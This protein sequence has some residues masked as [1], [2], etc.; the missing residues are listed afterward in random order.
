LAACAAIFAVNTNTNSSLMQAEHAAVHPIV[1]YSSIRGL[2]ATSS[3]LPSNSE[4]ADVEEKQE[5]A[6]LTRLE[7]GGADCDS[8]ANKGSGRYH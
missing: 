7:K 4:I 3:F 1:D 5:S 8:C 2:D 6:F